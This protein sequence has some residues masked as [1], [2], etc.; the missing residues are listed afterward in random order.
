MSQVWFVS[1]LHFGHESIIDFDNRPWRTIKEH[2]QGLID[3]WNEVVG[4]NDI[5]YVLGDVFMGEYAV[6]L[7]RIVDVLLK[8][9]GKI[10]IIGGN[11]DLA[12]KRLA[13]L[14]NGNVPK[15]REKIKHKVF[16]LEPKDRHMMIYPHP[17][18]YI[19]LC[20]YPRRAKDTRPQT[21]K[22]VLRFH[23]HT[24]SEEAYVNY[25]GTHHLNVAVVAHDFRPVKFETLI[26][27][28]R[29]RV[30]AGF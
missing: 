1:D 12:L 13:R 7:N 30:R 14:E 11:H 8:L 19:E 16:L 25:M 28:Y 17:R 3:R 24:H 6:K 26:E 15:L 22:P 27:T 9:N 23:G 29:K 21:M 4:K 18:Y 20:H 5:V 2:D 10:A